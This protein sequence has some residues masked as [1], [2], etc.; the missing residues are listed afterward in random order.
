MVKIPIL[1]PA[2]PPKG[3]F[4]PMSHLQWY[5]SNIYKTYISNLYLYFLIPILIPANFKFHTVLEAKA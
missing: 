4:F 3:T 5:V 2:F 1:N